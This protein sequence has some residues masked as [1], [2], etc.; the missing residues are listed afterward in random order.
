SG[1]AGLDAP[2]PQVGEVTWAPKLEPVELRLDFRRPAA[3]LARV[4]RVGRAWTTWRGRRLLVESARAV[5][6][7]APAGPPGT[8]RRLEVATGSGCLRLLTVRPEGRQALAA[9]DWA[10]GARLADEERLGGEPA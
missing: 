7:A 2:S 5:P 8:M 3:E 9:E 4:V 1:L 6:G 10:R